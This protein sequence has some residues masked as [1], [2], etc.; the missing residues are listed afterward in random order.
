MRLLAEIRR[1][2]DKNEIGF[3]CDY[4]LCQNIDVNP[5][6]AGVFSET[7]GVLMDYL[8]DKRL[9]SSKRETAEHPTRVRG[10]KSKINGEQMLQL[11]QQAELKLGPAVPNE[12]TGPV[13]LMVA[14]HGGKQM[15]RRGARMWDEAPSDFTWLS[16]SRRL[17]F[18]SKTTRFRKGGVGHAYCLSFV[19]SAT[20]FVRDASA[21]LRSSWAAVT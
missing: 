19:L 20:A 6:N 2:D 13:Y 10:T 14:A 8:S 15:R 16:T 1:R 9:Q 12:K 17:L 3:T 11:L 4:C 21:R 5:A 7:L 18:I